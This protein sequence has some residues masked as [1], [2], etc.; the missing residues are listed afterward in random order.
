MNKKHVYIALALLATICTFFL[1]NTQPSTKHMPHSTLQVTNSNGI[2]ESY[3]ILL[4]DT[5]ESRE[6]GLGG[7]K[8]IGVDEVMVF[9][10]EKSGKHFFWM[11]DMLF[12]IDIVWLN[13]DKEVIHIEREVSPDSFP[14]SFGPNK[15]S[16][17]VLEFKSGVASST[18]IKIGDA[19]DF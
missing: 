2:V 12:A 17:Y 7:R 13:A 3:K 14:Q 10:F 6:K 11:K 15:E 16:K 19:I 1:Y 5:L 4:A 8:S 9:V 18:G